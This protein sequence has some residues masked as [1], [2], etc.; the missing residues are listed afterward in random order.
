MP[1]I[2]LSEVTILIVDDNLTNLEVLSDYLDELNIEVIPIKSGKRA[3][4]F[5]KRNSCDLILLDIMMPEMDGYETCRSIKE[6]PAT[7]NIPII[8]MSALSE[9]TDKIKGFQMGAVDYITKPFQQ[10]EVLVRI[11]T[12]VSL[13]RAYEQ[14]KNQ[15][16]KIQ[17]ANK[18]ICDELNLARNIQQGLLKPVHKK[19]ENLE[20]LCYIE[21]AQEVG[22]DFYSYTHFSTTETYGITVGD[23]SGKGVSAALLMATCLS[24]FNFLVKAD[25][26]LESFI[27][28]LDKSLTPYM[29]PYKQNCALVYAEITPPSANGTEPGKARF[30]N[31]GCVMPLIRRLNG[32]IEWIVIGGLPLGMGIG[33]ELGY[34]EQTTHLQ[35]GDMIIFST[36]GLPESMNN[37]RELFGFE[38]MEMAL[39][40]F[41]PPAETPVENLSSLLLQHFKQEFS[42]F[43]G[44][45]KAHDDL[46]IVIIRL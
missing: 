40:S 11:K 44:N 6:N 38:R 9:T 25:I 15:N 17:Q 5:L 21:S 26:P 32:E 24:Q 10:D 8:F 34:P 23:V 42:R 16:E 20:L 13:K 7:K 19:W 36:D 41:S 4:R 22:G 28:T 35:K 14:L 45:A 29:K 3:L 33:H 30:V 18:Q 43:V 39:S 1:K 2:N 46:T 37:M 12:H 27:L 31:A